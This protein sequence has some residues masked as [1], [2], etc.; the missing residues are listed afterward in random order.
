[1]FG[2]PL[3]EI[4]ASDGFELKACRSIG[5]RKKRRVEITCGWFA[6]HPDLPMCD[7]ITLVINPMMDYTLERYSCEYGEDIVSLSA[8][9]RVID[10]VPVPG[11]SDA[12]SC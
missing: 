11:G 6:P 9:Y 4:V 7:R 10:G 8:T 12:Q 1:M 5:A 2:L 3:E